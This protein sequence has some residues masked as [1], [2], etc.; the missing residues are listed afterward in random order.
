MRSLTVNNQDSDSRFE[1]KTFGIANSNSKVVLGTV[2]LSSFWEQLFELHKITSIESFLV[3]FGSNG[4]L[5]LGDTGFKV[6]WDLGAGRT[7][8]M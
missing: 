3:G 7:Q 8:R 5:P 6:G 2:A 4:L 1:V